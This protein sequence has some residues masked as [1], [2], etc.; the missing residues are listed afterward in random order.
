MPRPCQ[1]VLDRARVREVATVFHSLEAAEQ[2][3]DD[4]LRAGFDRADIDM[5]APPDE[6]RRKL[7]KLPT[8]RSRSSPTWLIRHA[9]RSWS[10]M[11]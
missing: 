2:A 4:L 9:S 11:I 8:L 10:T 3:G 1:T 5:I 6:V 7:G